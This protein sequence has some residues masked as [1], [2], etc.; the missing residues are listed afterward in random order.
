MTE[1]GDLTMIYLDSNINANISKVNDLI[2]I[3][4]PNIV[5]VSTGLQSYIPTIKGVSKTVIQK[6]GSEYHIL[7]SDDGNCMLTTGRDIFITKV[8]DEI[9]IFTNN[10]MVDNE[11]YIKV[12]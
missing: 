8:S 10:E 4:F 12:E 7:I 5:M 11:D 9:I 6:N 3:E 2:I 1:R